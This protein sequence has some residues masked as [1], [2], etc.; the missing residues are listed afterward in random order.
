MNPFLNITDIANLSDYVR[1]ETLDPCYKQLG[2][3]DAMPRYIRPTV[4]EVRTLVQLIGLKGSKLGLAV[5]VDSRTAR[6][7]QGDTGQSPK[8][9]E[10]MLICIIA[11]KKLAAEKTNNQQQN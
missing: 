3:K 4:S 11:A 1:A 10:W 8:Y 7:W 2:K 6:R 5:G 9:S